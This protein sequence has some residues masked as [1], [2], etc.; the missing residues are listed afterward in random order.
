MNVVKYSIEAFINSRNNQI[1]IT[2]LM[3]NYLKENL[4][5]SGD[6]ENNLSDQW[7]NLPNEGVKSLYS[8]KYLIGYFTKNKI[9][10]F[11]KRYNWNETKK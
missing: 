7:N 10:I 8:H 3:T 1:P 11:Q 2:D 5:Y 9:Q 4:H 6:Y